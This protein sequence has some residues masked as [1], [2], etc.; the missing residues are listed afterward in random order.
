ML[1]C[2]EVCQGVGMIGSAQQLGEGMVEQNKLA[3]SP[4]VTPLEHQRLLAGTIPGPVGVL[5]VAELQQGA[6][7][8]TTASSPSREGGQPAPPAAAGGAPAGAA[9]R[10]DATGSDATGSDATSSD[11]HAEGVATPDRVNEADS[12]KL[13]GR[14]AD[15]SSVGVQVEADAE[16]LQPSA[17]EAARCLRV[18][19]RFAQQQARNAPK[20]S[21]R[22][23]MAITTLATF[24]ET[25]AAA[26]ERARPPPAKSSHLVVR[27]GNVKLASKPAGDATSRPDPVSKPK[28][29]KDEKKKLT[30]AERRLLEQQI[31][32]SF[33]LSD[34]L[35]A[36]TVGA[37]DLSTPRFKATSAYS[38]GTGSDADGS[39]LEDT[40][41]AVYE[42][43]HRPRERAERTAHKEVFQSTRALSGRSP[44]AGPAASPRTSP[45]AGATNADRA[46]AAVVAPL[47]LDGSTEE[48]DDWEVLGRKSG[49]NQIVLR[50]LRKRRQD[51]DG[52]RERKLLRAAVYAHVSSN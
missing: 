16:G 37:T 23:A 10:A 5:G 50:K 44:R 48:P 28:P 15:R 42:A 21:A 51:D 2:E 46:R 1:W 35:S 18:A 14:S 31:P 19:L 12:K 25:Q 8:A 47:S 39:D 32:D 33:V 29:P 20:P 11:A 6:G 17:A 3:S 38:A 36:K 26:A 30:D 9:R 41:D 52:E 43:M 27:R 49:T 45:R 24:V 13:S 4:P 22:L 7:A 40:S 34:A